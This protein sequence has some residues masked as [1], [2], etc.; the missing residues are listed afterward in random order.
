[1][2]LLLT[3]LQRYSKMV[4]QYVNRQ[5]FSTIDPL[6][7]E[8]RHVTVPSCNFHVSETSDLGLRRHAIHMYITLRTG[9]LVQLDQ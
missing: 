3:R 2:V 5:I 6:H 9:V 8:S 7:A 1:M 4:V